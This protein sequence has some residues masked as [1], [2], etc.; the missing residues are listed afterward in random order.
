MGFRRRPWRH[1]GSRSSH[2]QPARRGLL[3]TCETNGVFCIG[4]P[5]L[6]ESALVRGAGAGRIIAVQ[7]LGGNS[8]L[9]GIN[10][11]PGLVRGGIRHRRP[12][13]A[14]SLP[15]RFRLAW[16]AHLGPGRKELYFESQKFSGKCLSGDN[17]GDQLP[18]QKACSS[19]SKPPIKSSAV[20]ADRAVQAGARREPAAFRLAGTYGAGHP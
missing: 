8:Y 4:A 12:R 3:V 20:A 18:A 9:V 7:A 2:R 19:G 6:R 11:Q 14:P 10:A 15:A 16:K 1:Q 5:S 13:H 17:K